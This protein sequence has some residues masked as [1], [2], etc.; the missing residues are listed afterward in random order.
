MYFLAKQNIALSKCEYLHT[1]TELHA[2]EFNQNYRNEIKA[3]EFTISIADSF[4]DKIIQDIKSSPFIG[5]QAD[6]STDGT[7]KSYLAVAI[8]YIFDGEV[9]SH[10][11]DMIPLEK[12][13]AESIFNKIWTFL[14]EY[15]LEDKLI[16]LAVDGAPTMISDHQNGVYGRLKKRIHSLI[17]NHCCIHKLLA[18]AVKSLGQYK[19]LKNIAL[20]TE[21]E[22]NELAMKMEIKTFNTNIHSL[23]AFLRPHQKGSKFWRT[24]NWN[25]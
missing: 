15:Q 3:K 13:N 23:I 19:K 11:I 12:Q 7:F 22:R 5:I 4:K 9:R 1:L 24:M 6:E 17:V 16:A 14:T 18:L 10:F 20:L 21:N 8:Q 2:R 25:S